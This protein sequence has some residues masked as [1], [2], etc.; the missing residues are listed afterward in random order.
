MVP[1]HPLL[2]LWLLI[3]TSLFLHFLLVQSPFLRSLM[4]VTHGYTHTGRR[5][6]CCPGTCIVPGHRSPDFPSTLHDTNIG[7]AMSVTLCLAV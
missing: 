5:H 3:P 7:Q 1:D 4:M 6:L 2:G